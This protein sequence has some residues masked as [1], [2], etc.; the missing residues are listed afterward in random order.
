MAARPAPSGVGASCWTGSDHRFLSWCGRLVTDRRDQE[1]HGRRDRRAP[2]SRYFDATP[3]EC[4]A[5]S[6]WRGIQG[7]TRCAALRTLARFLGGRRWQTRC[8]PRPVAGCNMPASLSWS[9][10][11]RW[12]ETTRAERDRSRGNDRPK[13]GSPPGS[14]PGRSDRR[15]GDSKHP[16]ERSKRCT[17]SSRVSSRSGCCM[18]RCRGPGSEVVSIHQRSHEKPLA[19]R[20][21]RPNRQLG[22][23]RSRGEWRR[24]NEPLP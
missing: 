19:G 5:L 22:G 1:A 13:G 16:A 17:A 2:L 14:G 20:P 11:S 9:K 18:S 8:E 12:W 3:S 7:C 23:E 4:R 6:S 15:R 10:P 24:P 21:R